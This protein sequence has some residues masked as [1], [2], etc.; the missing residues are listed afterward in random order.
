[1]PSRI[2][3]AR[4]AVRIAVVGTGAIGRRHALFCADEPTV[5]LVGIVDPADNA[6]TFAADVG[7]N[8]YRTIETLLERQKVDGVIIAAPTQLHR[9]IAVIAISH[10]VSV[11]IEKPITVLPGEADELIAAA[12]SS[13]AKIL[14]GH[15]RRHNP[16]VQHAR[17]IVTHELGRL[18]A[19]NVIWALL[20][21]VS[22]FEPDWRRRI[23]AGPILTN[24]VHDIDLLRF[25]CG[26]ISS[27]TAKTTASARSHEV[28]D[29]VAVLLA[30]ENGALG[31]LIGSDASP[32]PW[33]WDLNSGE[34][35]LFPVSRE[36]SYRFFGTEGSL[37]FPDL[38]LWRYRVDGEAGWT[39]P[40]SREGRVV[41]AATDA[42]RLQ[43]QHFTRVI[44]GE[45]EPLVSGEDGMRSLQA[46]AAI[47]DSATTGKTIDPSKMK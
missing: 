29:T 18:L 15:H 19:V 45:E 35:P 3:V 17:K 46:T 38:H 44:T 23:G 16:I 1:M 5:D 2:S 32:S 9:N 43:L 8:H 20:K 26:E 12:Q 27:V 28:E 37:E 13:G 4:P 41:Q 7:V 24:L 34:N 10:G 14:V 47:F 22:Y 30:F 11:L 25:L 40:I 42:Y 6:A 31:T 36:N 39:Q 21:P 33:S